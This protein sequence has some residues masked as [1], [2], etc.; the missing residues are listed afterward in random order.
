M[1]AYYVSSETGVARRYG[2]TGTFEASRWI[3]CYPEFNRIPDAALTMEKG[4]VR[5]ATE[6][7]IR[8]RL[9]MNKAILV[10]SEDELNSAVYRA[11]TQEE[12]D[13]DDA[14]AA[15]DA[16]AAQAK[17]AADEAALIDFDSDPANADRVL[18]AALIVLIDQLSIASVAAGLPALK[19]ADMMAQIKATAKSL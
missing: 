16:A 18:R 1:L 13:A 8:L 4:K 19:E 5:L 12:T 14:K 15:A 7:E 2:E 17:A 6:E 10:S 9:A 11:K 3:G